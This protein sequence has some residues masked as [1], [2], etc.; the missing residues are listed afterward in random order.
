MLDV[1]PHTMMRK[2]TRNE[3]HQANVVVLID[4]FFLHFYHS[5]IMKTIHLFAVVVL[6][7]TTS[8][9]SSCSPTASAGPD[10]TDDILEI[11]MRT[12]PDETKWYAALQALN[13]LTKNENGAIGS[14][15]FKAIY[16]LVP[17]PD[18]K[19]PVFFALGQYESISDYNVILQKYSTNPPP[20]V[21]TDYFNTNQP[22]A[23]V[24]A[25]PFK[26]GDTFDIKTMVSKGQVLEVAIRDI[27]GY[28]NKSD[29]YAKKDAFIAELKKQPG[30]IREYEWISLDGKYYI[31]M[32]KYE[33]VS[34]F[35]A[36]SAN[37]TFLAN[38]A[39]T[40]MFSLY[41][42]NTAAQMGVMYP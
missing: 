4:M 26:A 38:K 9:L 28:T 22:F 8:I 42:P 32:T 27:S 2:D 30:V 25:K 29:F 19:K 37:T 31:G 11:A 39:V 15:E 21:L 20:K 6:I 23:Q 16:G 13:S 34:A 40:D 18:A 35:Q 7:A 10:K 41:P 12:V 3:H 14:Q 36:I 33:S 24:L 1:L 17:T 5:M